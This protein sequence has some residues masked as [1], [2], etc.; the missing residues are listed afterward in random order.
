MYGL[1]KQAHKKYDELYK[2][3]GVKLLKPTPSPKAFSEGG[4]MGSANSRNYTPASAS[5]ATDKENI[6]LTVFTMYK[7]FNEGYK[8]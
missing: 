3:E 5:Q 7:S 8:K 1:G 4:L 6:P 2:K